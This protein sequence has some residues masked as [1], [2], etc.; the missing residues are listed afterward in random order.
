MTTIIIQALN[1]EPKLQEDPAASAAVKKIGAIAKAI[2]KELDA[3]NVSSSGRRRRIADAAG[4][5]VNGRKKK[6]TLQKLIIQLNT[7]KS[8][9]NASIALVNVNLATKIDEE[10]K[11]FVARLEREDHVAGP[12]PTSRTI[13]GNRASGRSVM[14]NAP[15][16]GS[17][18]G[19]ELDKVDNWGNINH[20]TISDNESS[21]SSLMMNYAQTLTNLD[22]LADNVLAKVR[23]GIDED[24]GVD[25]DESWKN[26]LIDKATDLLLFKP[27][28][29]GSFLVVLLFPFLLYLVIGQLFGGRFIG[30]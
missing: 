9:L 19:N 4:Q 2:E 30:Q 5:L 12:G 22:H 8:D 15:L 26:T 25:E 23:S 10:V 6:S 24:E 16:I 21:G 29:S 20:V 28:M 1:H 14:S 3:S 17:E 27:N 7:Y 13:T 11:R 18:S